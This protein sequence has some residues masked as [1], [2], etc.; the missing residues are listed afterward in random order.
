MHNDIEKILLS[1]QQIQARIQE[2]GEVLTKEYAD[3]NPVI[4]GVLKGVVVSV[5]TFLLYK[6]VERLLKMK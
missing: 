3:K 6:R 2:L 1:E 4:V 5:L